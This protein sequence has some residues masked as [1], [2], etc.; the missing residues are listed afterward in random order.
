MEEPLGLSLNGDHFGNCLSTAERTNGAVAVFLPGV[1]KR[2]GEL[3][4]SGF[5][6][7]FT[8]IHEAMIH[9]ENSADLEGLKTVLKDTVE[10]ATPKEDVLTLNIYYYDRESGEISMVPTAKKKEI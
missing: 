1:A 5:Y 3:L 6:I 9:S 4:G 10:A 7:V 2:L 8:S